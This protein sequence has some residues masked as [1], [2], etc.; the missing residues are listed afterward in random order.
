[1]WADGV[2][3]KAGLERKK[4]A[5]LLVVIGALADGTKEVLAVRTVIPRPSLKAPPMPPVLSAEPVREKF[6][7]EDA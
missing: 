6:Q 1:M 2:Y 3:V 5:A 7:W 4:K